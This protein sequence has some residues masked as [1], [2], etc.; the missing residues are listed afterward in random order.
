[1][2]IKSTRKLNHKK[3]RWTNIIFAFHSS[4]Q[5]QFGWTFYK[6]LNFCSFADEYRNCLNNI[7]IYKCFGMEKYRDF[8]KSK[9]GMAHRLISILLKY[10][11]YSPYNLNMY[12]I[13]YFGKYYNLDLILYLIFFLCF[14]VCKI[15]SCL[16]ISSCKCILWLILAAIFQDYPG[17]EFEES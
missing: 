1:M 4:S 11:S 2:L 3:V 8:F 10:E 15:Y 12:Y 14:D 9:H 6:W 17:T 13:F 5:F 16:G 7:Q